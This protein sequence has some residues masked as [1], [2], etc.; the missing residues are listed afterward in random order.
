VGLELMRSSSLSALCFAA[1]AATGVTGCSGGGGAPGGGRHVRDSPRLVFN[2]SI[3]DVRLNMA[4][5]EVERRYG[6]PIRE[7]ALRDY[8]PVGTRYQGRKLLR[9]EPSGH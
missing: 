9:G 7:T 8:F 3:G 1:I 4:H 6:D 2:R 5:A